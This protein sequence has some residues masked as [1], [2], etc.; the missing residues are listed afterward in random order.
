MGDAARRL[1]TVDVLDGLADERVEVID[2]ELVE[3]AMT[4]FAHGDAQSSLVGEIKPRVRG[5]DGERPGWWIATE[6]TV[7]YA[8]TQGFRH[9]VAGWRKDRVPAR[10]EGRKV[11]TRPDWVCEILSTNRRKDLEDKRRV[12]HAAGV[13]HYW[14]LD[15]DGQ[16]LTVLRH[17]AAGY[18]VVTV[19]SPGDR[20]H[21]EPF[22][23]LELEV[24]RLF[25]DVEGAPAS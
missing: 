1:L 3:E 16:T 5:G 18:V 12:L 24:V 23:E 20:A 11:A 13:P 19:V 25:G 8:P 6:V 17:H 9:D 14:L 21:L 2:G 22:D 4:S 10:P 7:V 15:P